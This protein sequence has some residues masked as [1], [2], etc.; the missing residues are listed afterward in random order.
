LSLSVSHTLDDLQRRLESR[1]ALLLLINL[2]VQSLTDLLGDGI[3]IDLDGGH[4]D[5]GAAEGSVGVDGVV[6]AQ[7]EMG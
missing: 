3:A 1:V 6:E 2:R 7:L 4:I 5:C